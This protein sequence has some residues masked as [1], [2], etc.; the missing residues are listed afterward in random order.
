MLMTLEVVRNRGVAVCQLLLHLFD[1]LS[2]GIGQEELALETHLLVVGPVLLQ[3]RQPGIV[4]DVLVSVFQGLKPEVPVRLNS[5]L[6]LR[7]LSGANQIS[8]VQTLKRDSFSWLT[9]LA[10]HRA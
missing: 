3:L 2:V 1:E 5:P 7:K 10:N 9:V 4:V 8:N 6:E